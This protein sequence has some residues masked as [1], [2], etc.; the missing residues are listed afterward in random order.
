MYRELSG[1]TCTVCIECVCVRVYVCM[2]ANVY[3]CAII[4]RANRANGNCVANSRRNAE[5]I[6]L[7]TRRHYIQSS[8]DTWF[9]EIVCDTAFKSKGYQTRAYVIRSTIVKI[10]YLILINLFV[11]I[12]C[13]LSFSHHFYISFQFYLIFISRIFLNIL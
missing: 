13:K 5:T 3:I 9:S 11:I 8:L 6:H 10:D 7:V 4:Q 12:F 1:E 2:H